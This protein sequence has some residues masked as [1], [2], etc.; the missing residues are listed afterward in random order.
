MGPGLKTS[1]DDLES[2]P[3]ETHNHSEECDWKSKTGMESGYVV[4]TT[5]GNPYTS[6]APTAM[7]MASARLLTPSFE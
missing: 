5:S 1:D 2:S 3:E 4:K 7:R 6:F